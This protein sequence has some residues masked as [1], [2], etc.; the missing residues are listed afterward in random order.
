PVANGPAGSSVGPRCT[1]APVRSSTRVLL[2]IVVAPFAA[3][4]PLLI[5]VGGRRWRSIRAGPV[6]VGNFDRFD[7]GGAAQLWKRAGGF[8]PRALDRHRAAVACRGGPRR[9]RT[10]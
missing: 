9:G 4:R 1:S 5:T 3:P 7:R 10:G 8:R 2:S 6:P